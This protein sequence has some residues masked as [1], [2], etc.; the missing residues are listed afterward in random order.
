MVCMRRRAVLVAGMVLSASAARGQENRPLRLVVPFPAGGPADSLA[1][2]AAGALGERLGQTVVVDNRPGAGGNI[3]AEYVARSAPDGTALLLAGQAIMCINKALYP[4]LS[5]DPDADFAFVGMVGGNA[6]VLLLNTTVVP[7][8][9]LAGLAERARAEPRRIAFGSNGAGSLAHLTVEVMAS[10]TGCSFLHVPYRGSAPMQT[11]LIAGRIALAVTGAPGAVPL[12]QNPTLRALAVT[13]PHRLAALPDV[14]TFT[15]LGVPALNAPSWFGL[16]APAA[17]PA[18]VLARLQEG[19][20]AVNASQAYRDALAKQSSE[21]LA[22]SPEQAPEFLR[23][24]R[25]TWSQA[26][27]SSGAT[28]E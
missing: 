19:I 20:Q 3:A 14:P 7:V 26:V 10:A 22:L 27:R 4:H 12:L 21:Q 1:R 16:F 11:D 17:T 25:A 5:Y 15:E 13:T 28:V 2:I 6:N 8:R 24:E 23:A 18:P 9:D